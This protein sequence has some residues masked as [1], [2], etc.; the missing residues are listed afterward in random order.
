MFYVF[1]GF[2]EVVMLELFLSS[3]ERVAKIQPQITI[4][5]LVLALLGSDLISFIN[6]FMAVM[7]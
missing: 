5:I 4:L 6:D 7:K 2:Q 3:L 1:E